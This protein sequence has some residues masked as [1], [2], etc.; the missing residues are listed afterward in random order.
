[1]RRG[2]TL[3]ATIATA[4]AA[5]T[6]A[7]LA[8]RYAAGAARADRS[9]PSQIEGALG[10]IGQVDQVT[11]L[12]LVERLT[13]DGSGLAGEP[14]VCY[15][16]Q[17]GRTRIM[18]DS[19]LSGGKPHSALA[20]NVR[21]LGASLADLDAVVISHLHADH[22]G[23]IRAMRAHTFS[24]A[25]EPLEPVGIPA[26]VPCPMT[27]PRADIAVTARPQVIA[28]G[29]A[30]LPPLP[31]MLFWP[32]YISEQAMVVNVRGF[33]L[34]LISGCGHPPIEKALAVTEQVLDVPI[35]AVVGGL[36]LPVHAGRTPLVPQAVLGNPHLPWQPIS[37]RDAIQ[38]LDEI[39]ARGP[40]LVALSG[41]DSTPWTFGAFAAR[42]GH[43]YRTLRAG[44]ELT[45]SAATIS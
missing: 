1:M 34:V 39:E 4:G 29:V 11:I 23:G 36:H 30:L 14:G 19:G 28:Q 43:R 37:E 26:H 6:I 18:F 31:R 44:E 22:V 32:G 12:P 17:A 27:H 15:L 13:I 40:R 45:I 38:V 9:W 16:V 24:F 3:A 10:G 33:G 2:T 35:Q 5:A 25:A 41:H 21:I 8:G 20:R 7:R 42:F